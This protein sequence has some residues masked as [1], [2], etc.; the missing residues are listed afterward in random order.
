MLIRLSASRYITDGG[1]YPAINICP[2]QMVRKMILNKFTSNGIVKC[3]TRQQ[4]WFYHN[5]KRQQ[6]HNAKAKNKTAGDSRQY[7]VPI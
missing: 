2:F 1:C 5:T 3:K 4:L 7:S 6:Y